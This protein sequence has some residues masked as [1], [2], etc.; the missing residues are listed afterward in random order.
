MTLSEKPLWSTS[1]RDAQI[2]IA[3]VASPKQLRALSC[4]YDWSHHP[5]AVLGWVMAQKTIDLGT[6]LIVFFNGEPERF[7]YMP[8][9][10]VPEDYHCAARVLDNICLRVNSGYYLVENKRNLSCLVEK[11]RNLSCQRRLEKWLEYQ[12]ADRK[13]A[14]RGRWILDEQIVDS[15]LKPDAPKKAHAPCGA[16]PEIA[17][18]SDQPGTRGGFF[19][20]IRNIGDMSRR[21]LS[22]AP[23]VDD[24]TADGI[25]GDVGHVS[26][27]GNRLL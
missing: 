5:E 16:Q 17:K 27:P 20:Q 15:L 26:K 10:D 18:F 7:N 9:R 19:A 23:E 12:Q 24:A 14:R 3:K 25:L 4:Q 21:F 22:P 6:A 11:K 2:A 8:K 13:D 1:D